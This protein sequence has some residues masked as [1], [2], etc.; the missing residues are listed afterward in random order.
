MPMI[1]RTI[2]DAQLPVSR[3]AQPRPRAAAVRTS[4]AELARRTC[5]PLAERLASS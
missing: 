5:G 1:A 3:T 4:L 2:H